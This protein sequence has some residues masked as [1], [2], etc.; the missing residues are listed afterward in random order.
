VSE[1]NKDFA[2]AA[3][4]LAPSEGTKDI[5]L[6]GNKK[7]QIRKITVGELSDIL[8]V[9]RDNELE[10]FMWLAFKGL[11]APKMTFDQIK[12]MK[13][14][15]LLELVAEIQKHSD[16]DKESMGRLENL[17]KDKTKS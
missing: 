2:E 5:V 12:R 4:L 17:L 7:V 15:I 9:A 10:Q 14:D 3:D 16:L 6:T 1:T 11:V 13:H 8:K